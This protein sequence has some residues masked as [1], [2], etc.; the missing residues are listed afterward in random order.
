MQPRRILIA[1]VVTFLLILCFRKRIVRWRLRTL[2]TEVIRCLNETDIVYWVDFGTLL[3]IHR[4][5]DII[6]GDNDVDICILDPSTDQI[7]DL[8][9]RVQRRGRRIG[10]EVHAGISRVYD[11]F[12]WDPF[13]DFV[14]L[15]H[16]RRSQDGSTIHG[17][18]GASSD[19]PPASG[20]VWLTPL[21][22]SACLCGNT[23]GNV[24]VQGPHPDTGTRACS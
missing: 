15:Y 4:E 21:C 10:V 12:P 2:A 19:I 3:G 23:S 7:R 1:V 18:T 16:V 6:L 5:G 8:A 20:C 14:D 11:R 13:V 24:L 22:G 17:A 9:A